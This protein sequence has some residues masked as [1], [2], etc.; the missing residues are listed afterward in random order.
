MVEQPVLKEIRKYTDLNGDRCLFT[1]I[2][3]DTLRPTDEGFEL[4]IEKLARPK[5]SATSAKNLNM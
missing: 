2:A 3:N 5:T 1:L 4:F